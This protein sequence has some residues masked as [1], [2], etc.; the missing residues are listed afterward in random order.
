MSKLRPKKKAAKAARRYFGTDGIRG[1]VNESHMTAATAMRL[2]AA[3]GKIFQR[4]AHKHRAVIGKDTRISGYMVESALV[5]GLTSMGLNVFQFGP[6]PTPAVGFLTRTLRADLGVMISA[7]H[8][9]F[10]DNGIKLFGPDGYKLSDALELKIERL[11]DDDTLPLAQAAALGRAKRI[12]DAQARYIEFAKRSFPR[13]MTLEGVRIVIDC[14]H[15]AAYKVAPTALWELGAE[16]I[17]LGDAPNGF[18]INKDCGALAPERLQEAVVAHKAHIGLAL[19]GDADRLLVCDERG[20]AV[21]GDQLLALLADDWHA[22]GALQSPGIVATIMSN[23][24]LEHYLAQRG[25][26]LKRTQVG[27]RYVVAYMRAH[28]YNLGGEPSGHVI[29]RNYTTTGDGLIAGLQVLG[30]LLARAKPVSEVLHC[31]DPVPQF[32]DNMRLPQDAVLR[33][34]RV[35]KALREGQKQLGANG[36]LLMRKSGTEP[37]LRIMGEGENE[38][39]TRAAM[40]RLRTAIDA[41][42]A[43][44]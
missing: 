26:A 15:G 14:A 11:M 3:A 35:Q 42:E 27:D 13:D 32:V 37:I 18:N 30:I 40:E 5:A 25:L 36:R 24:G 1:R 4:G 20:R 38:A 31:F 41:I 43:R 12:D 6:I 9:G 19:D 2:G 33:A 21:D 22:R 23:L 7:S 39:A 34:P 16:V 17:P 29:L 8:N 10:H 44:A 28:N